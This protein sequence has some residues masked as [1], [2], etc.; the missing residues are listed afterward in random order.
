M[1]K[2]LPVIAF[3]AI[4][5]LAQLLVSCDQTL[6]TCMTSE[7]NDNDTDFRHHVKP[8]QTTSAGKVPSQ[9]DVTQRMYKKKKAK[10]TAN[11]SSTSF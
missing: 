5:T 6:T 2:V 4:I 9:N 8:R 7:R 10:W 1:I 3:I 11:D